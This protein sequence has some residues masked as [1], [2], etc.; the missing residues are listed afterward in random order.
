MRQERSDG[1]RRRCQIPEHRKQIASLQRW[2]VTLQRSHG[3][4]WELKRYAER[5]AKDLRASLTEAQSEVARLKASAMRA[6]DDEEELDG[7]M[8]ESM[9]EAFMASPDVTMRSVVRATKKG[10]RDRLSKYFNSDGAQ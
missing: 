1:G 3:L 5:D 4:M 10:I 9:R 8:P 2:A 7:P 6:I